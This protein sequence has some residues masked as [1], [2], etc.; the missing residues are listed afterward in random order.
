MMYGSKDMV[1]DGQTDRKS[2]IQRWVPQLNK[3]QYFE[4]SAIL[5]GMK[6]KNCKPGS[7]IKAYIYICQI[8]TIPQFIKEKIEKIVAQLSIWN[9]G[10]GILDIDTQ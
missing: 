7:F 1:H 6:K 3:N 8:Y 5:F 2:D 4:Q 9:C 10:L